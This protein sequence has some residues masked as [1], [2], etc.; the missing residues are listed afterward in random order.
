MLEEFA[1]RVYNAMLGRAVRGMRGVKPMDKRWI[2]CAEESRPRAAETL[3]CGWGSRAAGVL[4]RRRALWPDHRRGDVSAGLYAGSYSTGTAAGAD[5]ERNVYR[6]AGAIY[7]ALVTQP[8][9][10]ER[11]LFLC[12]LQGAR[13]ECLQ[14]LA[15]MQEAMEHLAGRLRGG[16]GDPWLDALC[17]CICGYISMRPGRCMNMGCSFRDSI[18]KGRFPDPASPSL[19]KFFRCHTISRLPSISRYTI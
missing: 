15:R 6:C 16:E 7:S 8:G 14:E 13:V 19:D 17:A 12:E 5:G 18:C 3:S 1:W 9:G 11:F 2:Q 4:C 10:R